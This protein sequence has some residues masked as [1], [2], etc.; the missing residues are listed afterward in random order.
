MTAQD[1][2][3]ELV[4]KFENIEWQQNLSIDDAGWMTYELQMTTNAAKQCALIAV[5]EIMK[6]SDIKKSDM[7]PNKFVYTDKYW[8][9]VREEIEKL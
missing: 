6:S 5:D 2:A 8:Q 3:K 7:N 9:S 1:K 4:S